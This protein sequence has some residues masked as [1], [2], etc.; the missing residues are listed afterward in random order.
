[1]HPFKDKTLVFSGK[2]AGFNRT[3]IEA[4]AVLIFGQSILQEKN[5]PLIF[6]MAY[7]N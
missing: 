1:M 2:I 5:P 6:F 3:Q 4:Y 7:N